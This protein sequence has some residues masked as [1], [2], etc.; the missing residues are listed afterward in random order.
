MPFAEFDNSYNFMGTDPDNVIGQEPCTNKSAE[1]Q[2]LADQYYDLI[3]KAKAI[4]TDTEARYTAF[5]EAEAF[6]IDHAFVIPYSISSEGYVAT[7][8][9]VFEAQYAPYG[10]ALQSFKFQHLR[11]E[12]MSMTEYDELYTQWLTDREAAQAAAAE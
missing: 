4:T 3:E 1:T 2:A 5:A 6:L 8:L 11:E 7:R 10:M 12:P 9:N